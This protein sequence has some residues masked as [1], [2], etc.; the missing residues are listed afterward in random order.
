MKI[1]KTNGFRWVS[2]DQ[3]NKMWTAS[4]Q[5]YFGNS[6]HIES[7]GQK[8]E[9]TSTME[10]I[11]I[12][13]INEM[14]VRLEY[15][16]N[17]LWTWRSSRNRMCFISPA[18]S[19]TNIVTYIIY[20]VKR[21]RTILTLNTKNNS[22][23]FA[24]QIIIILSIENENSTQKDARMTEFVSSFSSLP[25]KIFRSIRFGKERNATEY[26]I[27]LTVMRKRELVYLLFVSHLMV[28]A[29]CNTVSNHCTF[30]HFSSFVYKVNDN[31]NE[32]APSPY[33]VEW[34]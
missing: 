23:K 24:E 25:F 5:T 31:F 11:I 16:L 26:T 8:A 7:H 6:T 4:T 18:A 9:I 17:I 29:V 30:S 12:I 21:S 27:T 22:N 10:R 19:T 1:Q 15:L 2:A 33:Y 14:H 20:F 28:I 34:I 13:I 3:R 32:W